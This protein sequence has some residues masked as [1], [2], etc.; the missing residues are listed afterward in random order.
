MKTD[1]RKTIAVIGGGAAGFFAAIKCAAGNPECRVVI[2]EKSTKILSKVRVSGGGRCNVTHACYDFKKLPEFYPRGRQELI[3]SFSRFNVNH[4][5]EW[6]EQ[7]GVK[8][9]T[10][11]DGRM[12]P[13]TDNSQTIIDCLMDD[14]E[15]LNIVIELNHHLQ[16]I[17]KTNDD[18]FDLIFQD[19]K[20]FRCDKLI[21]T[22]GGYPMLKGFDFIAA[23]GHTIIVPVPSLFTFNIPLSPLKGLE[24]IAVP[25]ASISLEGT[26]LSETGPLLITHWGISGPA[27]IKLSAWA[28]RMLN[29]KKYE[30]NLHINWLSQKSEDQLKDFFT[31][32]KSN[33]PQKKVLAN[34]F[35][36]LPQR[37]WERLVTL[38]GI[39]EK[40]NVADL[41]KQKINSL[42]QLLCNMI[43][44]CK[45][46]TTYKEE[47]VTCGGVSLKEVN[48]QTMES[49]KVK[50]LYFAGE[51][52]DIDGITGGFNF[53]SAWTTGWIAGLN[54]ATS[55]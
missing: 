44:R 54:A 11:D 34:S 45:G 32:L 25:D 1:S 36:G 24:G 31:E 35:F 19:G 33:H 23:I 10:E 40:E 27:A 26:K 29:E 52:L 17:K 13:V 5:I 37:L 47:F 49:T 30:I 3:G 55:S 9:K 53:Q 41:S 18:S 51:V 21:L 46:K 38:S 7:R 8:L 48:L 4:T 28:A 20:S 2:F 15:R 6:F 50:G 22:V 43:L 16:Q 12:F 14:A 39:T 42:I